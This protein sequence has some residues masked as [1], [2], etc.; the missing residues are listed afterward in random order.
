MGAATTLGL[1]VFDLCLLS[2]CPVLFLSRCKITNNN[3][4]LAPCNVSAFYTLLLKT[5]HT[6][7]CFYAHLCSFFVTGTILF[8][9]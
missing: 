2:P 8:G 5:N 1:Y 4:K 6:T 3:Y 9:K 7:V